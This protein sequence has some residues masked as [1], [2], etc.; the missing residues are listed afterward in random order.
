MGAAFGSQAGAIWR[1]GG[2]S[3]DYKTTAVTEGAA[4][5]VLSWYAIQ[6]ARR[7]LWEADEGGRNLVRN[8]SGRDSWIGRGLRGR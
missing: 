5:V 1:D 4:R 8:A 2:G 3:D 7:L 6:N